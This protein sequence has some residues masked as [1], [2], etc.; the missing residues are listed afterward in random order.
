MIP[1]VSEQL[2]RFLPPDLLPVVL[3]GILFVL[4]AVVGQGVNAWVRRMSFK[5][6]I[7][8]LS[9]C[10][11]C[12]ARFP[13]WKLIPLLRWIPLQNRCRQCSTRLP[14]SE[15]LLELATGGLFALFY[16]MA[17]QQRCL[18]IPAVV[19]PGFM[20]E[21]RLLYHF[22]LLTLLVAATSIDF[23]EYLIPDQITMSGM[24]I[25]LLGA[26]I[27]G[28][29][30]IVH[31]WVDWNQAIP[32]LSGPYIP[33]WI[34]VHSH[35]HGLTWSLAGLIAGGGLTWILRLVS[36]VL[37]GQ[38]ALGFGDVTLMAMIGSFVGWQ[39]IL[40]ILPLAPLCGLLIGFISRMVTGK[41]YLP[42]GPYLCA[43]TLIVLMGWKWIWLAEWPSTVAGAPPEFSIRRLFGD[44]LG[45]A[46]LA[47]IA[48]GA[49]IVMLLLLRI[50]RAIPVK[51]R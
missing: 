42:Y 26:T 38:E 20:F 33:E 46:M 19:P 51:R 24:L 23:R 1:F 45:L 35:W 13:L 48:L 25:G 47:G 10:Q 16:F 34:K 17:V 36:S 41:T 29:L 37:L 5:P 15:F 21:W 22:V 8:P 27:A 44:A 30:Q 18:E 7:Q 9:R 40:L 50:Y 32:G 31:V 3:P 28:Q 49:L 43:A 14:R 6:G 12:G 39:P 11:A 2:N 4:G